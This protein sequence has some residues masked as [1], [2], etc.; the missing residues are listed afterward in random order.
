[1]DIRL[2]LWLPSVVL[3][4]TVWICEAAE[5][6]MPSNSIIATFISEHVPL[7]VLAVNGW[8]STT[9]IESALQQPRTVVWAEF[10]C[11]TGGVSAQLY[12]HFEVPLSRG[13]ML[14]HFTRDPQHHD[15]LSVVGLPWDRAVVDCL[16]C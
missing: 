6:D 5:L 11:G 7:D 10:F 15:I 14:D 8:G 9:A 1:M 2:R 12:K 13:R 4:H 16:T 3:F